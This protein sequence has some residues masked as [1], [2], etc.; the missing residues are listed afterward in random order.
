MDLC[1]HSDP[2]FIAHPFFLIVF[3]LHIQRPV[4][5]LPCNSDDRRQCRTVCYYTTKLTVNAEKD[6]LLSFGILFP[7]D[8]DVS[9]F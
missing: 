8:L 1:V 7:S 4:M 5:P 6:E 9:D 2:S 3:H